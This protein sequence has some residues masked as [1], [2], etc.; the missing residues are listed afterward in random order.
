MKWITN[1]GHTFRHCF[2]EIYCGLTFIN[3]D[4]FAFE[5]CFIKSNTI[6]LNNSLCITFIRI[7]IEFNFD[8]FLR[9]FIKKLHKYIIIAMRIKV[10]ILSFVFMRGFDIL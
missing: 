4:R 10:N 1:F 5:E 3:C 7:K 8:P 6:T 2:L 9:I